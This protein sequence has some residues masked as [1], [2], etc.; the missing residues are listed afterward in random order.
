MGKRHF[1]LD[2]ELWKAKSNRPLYVYLFNDILLL[3]EERRSERGLP[4]SLYRAPLPLDIIKL[5]R[6]RSRNDVFSINLTRDLGDKRPNIIALRASD[7][8]SRNNWANKMESA[9]VNI[10]SH[11]KSSLGA[12][13]KTESVGTLR[14][15]I[16]E[17]TKLQSMDPSIGKL[18]LLCEVSLPGEMQRTKEIRNSSHP[19]WNQSL[20]FGVQSLDDTLRIVVYNAFDRY[21]QEDYLGT[22]ELPLHLL[23]YYGTKETIHDLPLQNVPSGAS[24]KLR[25]QYRSLTGQS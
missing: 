10:Q 20:I 11:G 14:V 5:E 12:K 3:T 15:V 13:Q 19:V 23:E 7:V 24:I 18:N 1:I 21:S 2:G 9:C 16:V 25:L 8:N 22:A 4:W 17:G 6:D